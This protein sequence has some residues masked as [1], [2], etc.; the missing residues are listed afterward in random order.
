VWE[1]GHRVPFIVSWPEVIEPGGVNELLVHQA[2]F[3]A[4]FAELWKMD[5]P[6][7]AGED[8]FSLLPLLEGGTEPI[9]E[10]SVSCSSKGI[11]SMRM[12]SWKYIAA[13]GS[14]GWTQGGNPNEPVQL[15]DLAA[16]LGE[17][18]NLASAESEILTKIQ[19]RFE[20]EISRGRSTPGPEQ[21]NDGEVKRYPQP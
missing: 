15:Y 18:N 21:E 9:R 2:D 13:P 14:G 12:G 19:A 3:M 7:N 17:Q 4:T 1:G 10:T 16:D 20:E 8:S 6:E 11:P 5:L